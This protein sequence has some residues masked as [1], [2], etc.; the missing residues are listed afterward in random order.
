M[1]NRNS[2]VRYQRKDCFS[3]FE[4]YF[5]FTSREEDETILLLDLRYQAEEKKINE[6]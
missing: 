5:K 6:H 3:K 2:T 4:F 1:F